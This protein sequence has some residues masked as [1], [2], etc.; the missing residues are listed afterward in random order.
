MALV[1]SPAGWAEVTAS[2][3]SGFSLKTEVSLP[4]KPET[5][6]AS[7]LRVGQWWSD[8][9]TYSGKATN[10]TLAAEPNGC[11][12]ERLPQGGFVKHMEVLYSAPGQALRLGGGLGPLQQMG[13]T[14]VMTLIFKPEGDQVRLI[15][16]YGVSGF[17]GDIGFA[18]IA[19]LVDR[20]LTEQLTR[21]KHFTET[22][23]P[24]G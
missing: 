8:E 19:P 21:F 1:A 18:G 9:H 22:G 24:T 16:T 14:G 4:G 2:G 23:K 7:F 13:A 11:F 10:M 15:M 17:A 12:C 6:F 20:V 3:P 5:A